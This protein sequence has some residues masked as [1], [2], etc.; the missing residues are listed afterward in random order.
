M[1]NVTTSIDTSEMEERIADKVYLKLLDVINQNAHPQMQGS[2]FLT[3]RETM[4]ILRVSRGTLYKLINKGTLK[5]QAIGGR[6]FISSSV[7]Q[8]FFD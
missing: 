7:I 8:Q 2:D 6:R 1:L 4:A 5:S 3:I